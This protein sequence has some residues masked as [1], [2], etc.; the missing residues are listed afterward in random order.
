VVW[1]YVRDL[2]ELRCEVRP[3]ES[4]FLL[5]ISRPG[6]PEQLEQFKTVGG[7]IA[8]QNS[9]ERRLQKEGWQLTDFHPTHTDRVAKR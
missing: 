3:T 8:R 2:E 5:A 7:V 1:I 4:G 9:L 6:S